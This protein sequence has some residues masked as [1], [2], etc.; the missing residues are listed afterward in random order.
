MDYGSQIGFKEGD[1]KPDEKKEEVEKTKKSKKD[2]VSLRK[3]E[4]MVA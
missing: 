4:L 2:E 1:D 3:I